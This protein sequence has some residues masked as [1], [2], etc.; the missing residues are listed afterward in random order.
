MVAF[1]QA[2]TWPSNAP[3]TSNSP[4]VIGVLG[5]DPFGDV[6]DRMARDREGK[7]RLLVRRV[8]S[9]AE[10][11]QCQVVFIGQ[12]E[13]RNESAWLDELKDKSVLTIGESG[14]TLKRGGILELFVAV[15]KRVRYE[16]SWPAMERAR[17]KLSA[18]L[19]ACARKVH[20]PPHKR[21]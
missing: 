12:K 9:A 4:I 21:P 5:D 8:A 17:L 7:R 16:A 11:A 1:A 2:T 3:T 19:L 14:Q 18:D 13:S 20:Q 15:D 10:A 6:L